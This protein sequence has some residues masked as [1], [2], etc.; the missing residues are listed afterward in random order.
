MRIAI[1]GSGI[2]GL[3]A[4]HHL[5]RDHE[6][7]IYEAQSHIGGH[8]LTSSIEW[9]GR[10]YEVDAGF[11]VYNEV[12]YPNLV[13]LFETLGVASQPTGMS[14][15]VRDD[16][17]GLEYCGT[18]L[19][20]LFAQRRNLLRLTFH[21]LLQEIIRFNREAREL[22]QAGGVA[23]RL[24]NVLEQGCYSRQF[25]EQYLIPLGAAIWSTS[26]DRMLDFPAPFFLRFLDNHGLLSINGHHEW[27]TV[28]GGSH[29]YI[30]PLTR[31]FADRIRLELTR[32][33]DPA[34][35]RGG[36]HRDC[37][38]RAA[39]T[40]RSHPRLP[41]RPGTSAAGGAERSRNGRS[42]ARF[43]TSAMK[44]CF[45]PTPRCSPAESARGRAG[46][47]TCSKSP[48]IG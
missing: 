40:R 39:R 25:I 8:T 2:A 32:P 42:W 24:R 1:V 16:R 31:P 29:S 46:T 4:A 34:S 7:T 48:P 14:F 23:P 9:E 22:L 5:H 36:D 37:R 12:N 13:H 33:F 44:Q 28:R 18:S 27:R 41:Q 38:W 15:S 19:N 20:T 35:T 43:P 26:P 21:R 47:T 11:V 10:S 6:L 3:V 17:S 45:T 30:G